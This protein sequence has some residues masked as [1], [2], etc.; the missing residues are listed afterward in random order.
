MTSPRLELQLERQGNG[1]EGSLRTWQGIPGLELVQDELQQVE[2]MLRQVAKTEYPEL[3]NLLKHAFTAGGKR[4]RPALTLL[5]A[6]FYPTEPHKLLALAASIETL[7]TAT[8]I[9]DD[10][11]DQSL[12]RRGHPTM[13]VMAGTKVTILAGDYLFARAA[14]FAAVTKSS[15]IMD[16]FARALMT[17]CAG[18]IRQNYRPPDLSSFGSNGFEAILND[19][20]RRIYGKT[21]S[22]FEAA[23]EAA[24]VL[25]GAP[26]DQVQALRQYG[27]NLGMAFQIVDDVLDFTGD[28]RKLGKPAGSD[29]R[30][31][32]IT[33]PVINY[34]AAHPAH[35][36][37]MAA[38]TRQDRDGLV[39]EAIALIRRS[40]AILA[41]LDH[42]R[43]FTG[44]AQA[45]LRILPDNIYRQ[46]LYDLAEFVVE[47]KR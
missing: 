32:L 11:I 25:S 6:K 40:P 4:L 42:A 47:R 39:D 12:V 33:L 5:A 22:L 3:H 36:V 46:G 15:R 16:I 13:N 18:E 19:Y 41:S 34:L 31:G 43:E 45:Q 21:A 27:Y 35:P 9:H 7:H 17:L 1:S 2:I 23:T 20:H 10:V 38:L 26:E 29:L 14:E 24:A 44:A 28:E 30:Q 8:L 37:V